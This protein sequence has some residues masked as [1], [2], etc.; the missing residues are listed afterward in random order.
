MFIITTGLEFSICLINFILFNINRAILSKRAKY[1]VP[2]F[3][4][5]QLKA[6]FSFFTVR[7]SLIKIFEPLTNWCIFKSI[8]SNYFLLSSAFLQYFPLLNL[9][10]VI[11]EPLLDLPILWQSSTSL[12]SKLASIS[13]RTDVTVY[14]RSES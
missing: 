12:D 6:K 2:S 11:L 7:F 5:L 9:M 1:I 3:N 13:E 4:Y 14:S 8:F 10:T